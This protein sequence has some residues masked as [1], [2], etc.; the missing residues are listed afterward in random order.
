MQI[1]RKRVKLGTLIIITS[2]TP[3]ETLEKGAHS[4]SWPDRLIIIIIIKSAKRADHSS[5]SNCAWIWHC[6][7]NTLRVYG[8]KFI[9]LLPAP[10]TLSLWF[11]LMYF[12]RLAQT[13]DK[14]CHFPSLFGNWCPAHFVLAFVLEY[15]SSFRNKF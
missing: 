4:P 11:S 7:S 3:E 14:K 15:G 10:P 13:I 2:R 5:T 1:R 8:E 12:A 6:S 9:G